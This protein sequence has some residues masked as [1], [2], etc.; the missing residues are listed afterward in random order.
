MVKVGGLPPWL[1]GDDD[2]DK[3]STPTQTEQTTNDEQF[4]KCPSE[5]SPLITNPKKSSET[6]GNFNRT[7]RNCCHILFDFFG[8]LSLISSLCVI[9][10]QALPLLYIKDFGYLQIALKFYIFI[11]STM[12]IAAA[13]ESSCLK[14]LA[15]AFDNWVYRGLLQSF[16]GLVCIE[17]SMYTQSNDSEDTII[18]QSFE[19]ISSYMMMASG[20]VY[21]LMGLCCLRKLKVKLQKDYIERNKIEEEAAKLAFK[22]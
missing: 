18:V 14:S 17:E 22:V 10:S 20:V 21:F 19:I 6:Y 4:E 3:E 13:A 15:P 12:F 8:A 16:L 9:V 2:G 1:S 7:H 11:F 5:A